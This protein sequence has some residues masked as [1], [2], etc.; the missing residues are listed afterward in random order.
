MAFD[1]KEFKKAVDDS[2][3]AYLDCLE[4]G[5]N[6]LTEGKKGEEK[7][8]LEEIIKVSMGTWDYYRAYEKVIA[9]Y[10]KMGKDLSE[11]TIADIAK[12]STTLSDADKKRIAELSPEAFS[13]KI[14]DVYN[15]KEYNGFYSCL[16]D[17][18][19]GEDVAYYEFALKY[20]Y[21][22]NEFEKPEFVKIWR[23]GDSCAYI[24][25]YLKEA[26]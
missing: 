13:Y 26:V 7:P 8:S 11:I 22:I 9:I 14:Q 18:G 19:N 17:K 2:Q 24:N 10:Y 25:E 5:Y 12:Y 23:E 6:A 15:M 16:I 4:D 20:N 3:I 21:R 1:K